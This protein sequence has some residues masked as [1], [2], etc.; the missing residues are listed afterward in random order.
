MFGPYKTAEQAKNAR[1]LFIYSMTGNEQDKPDL[2]PND[3]KSLFFVEEVE[4]DTPKN[5]EGAAW[6]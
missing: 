5:N 2:S 3:Y 6:C 1:Q 4:C